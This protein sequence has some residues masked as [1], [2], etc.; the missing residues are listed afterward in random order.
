MNE[1]ETQ[2]KQQKV[3]KMKV[4]ETSNKKITSIANV[5]IQI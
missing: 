3:V 5:L 1:Y 4:K 2:K